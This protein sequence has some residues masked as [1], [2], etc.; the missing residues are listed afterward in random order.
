MG[1]LR[2]EARATTSAGIKRTFAERKATLCVAGSA[3]D[4]GIERDCPD[5]QV[6]SVTYFGGGWRYFRSSSERLTTR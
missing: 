5:C 1:G 2:T 3:R 6:K 4:Q